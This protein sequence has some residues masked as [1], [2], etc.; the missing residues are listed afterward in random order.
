MIAIAPGDRFRLALHRAGRVGR[1][2]RQGAAAGPIGRWRARRG[3][4]S[5]LVIAPPDI[6]TADPTVALDIYAGRYVFAGQVLETEGGSPF[7]AVPPS[8]DWLREL[9]GFGWLRHLRAADTPLARSNARAVVS[10]WQKLFGK[11][12][13]GPAWE[14]AVAA[15]RAL[16]LLAQSPLILADAD[17]GAYRRF[18]RC[19]LGHAAYLKNG[20]GACEPG[21]PRLKAAI[22]MA[23]IGLSLT[24]QERLARA[25]LERLDHELEVQILPDGGHVSRNPTALVDALVDLLPLRQALVAR[26]QSPSALLIGS[27]DRMLPMLRFFR[28]ADGSFAHFNGTAASASSLVP[29]LLA[30]DEAL[31]AP[32]SSAAYSGYERVAAGGMLMLVDAGRPPPIALSSEAHAGALAFEL[33]SGPHRIVI[34]CGA[35]A[36]R[37]RELRRA[38]RLTAAH[39]TAV[40]EDYSSCRFDGPESDAHIVAGPRSVTAR[41]EVLADGRVILELAHDGYQRRLGLVHQRRLVIAA[42]GSGVHGSDLF[43]GEALQPAIHFAVRFHL[44]P[45]VKAAPA[46]LPNNIDL[47]LPSREVWRFEASAPTTIEDSVMLSDV[48][49]TRRTHQIVLRDVV[50][51]NP[52]IGWRFERI[53]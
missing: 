43:P 6:R 44:H 26:G 20:I 39:S 41:R 29:A 32:I 14:T 5:E 19:L 2:L 51:K 46:D 13:G 9:H 24:R 36:A 42:D 25:G 38:A 45:A 28:H 52:A 40:L 21:L 50:Q 30:Y 37:H 11:P 35:P 27:I 53:R 8:Q 7:H 3:G 4:A 23:A 49:G 16:S 15:Q 1:K 10:D 34:N 22:A 47:T 48:V 31:G 18:V 17:H 33:S 12:A